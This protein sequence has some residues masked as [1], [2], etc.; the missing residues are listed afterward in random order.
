[1]PSCS[2]CGSRL[3]N[4]SISCSRCGASA[5]GGEILIA[6]LCQ[7]LDN[8]ASPS[9]MLKRVDEL[10][11][12]DPN[13]E[14]S[15]LGTAMGRRMVAEQFI[16]IAREALNRDNRNRA[17]FLAE[18]A[19]LLAPGSE[20]VKQLFSQI[21][22]DKWGEERKA[23]CRKKAAVLCLKFVLVV[24]VGLALF[25]LIRGCEEQIQAETQFRAERTEQQRKPEPPASEP[26]SIP[27]I[28]LSGAWK[29][30]FTNFDPKSGRK[31]DHEFTLILYQKEARI[32]GKTSEMI[33]HDWGPYVYTARI[34]GSINGDYIEFTKNYRDIGAVFVY[35]GR[36]VGKDRMEGTWNAPNLT[37][38]EW[39]LE[40][41]K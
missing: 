40:R 21:E 36:V 13:C 11:H 25:H 35:K 27:V 24:L 20:G 19:Q 28:D 1:M 15:Q 39:G 18:M 14:V 6:K 38:F 32:W 33:V 5:P 4:A 31:W 9:E 16:K 7:D 34:D 37:G 23:E 10:L 29:G 3:A 22:E 30:C 12:A 26:P 17:L 2:Y 8:D 41:V